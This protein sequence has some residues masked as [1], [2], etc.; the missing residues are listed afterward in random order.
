MRR[1]CN[2]LLQEGISVAKQGSS[3]EAILYF[4]KAIEL[5]PSFASA[6]F[7]RGMAKQAGND[8]IGAIADYT[9]AIQLKS[10]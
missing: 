1:H 10:D 7:V 4:D 6:Y 3:I 9:K 2:K 8:T 5:D